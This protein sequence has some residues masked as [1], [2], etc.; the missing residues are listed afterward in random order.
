MA[1]EKEEIVLVP[2]P[3][4]SLWWVHAIAIN[5]QQGLRKLETNLH[6]KKLLALLGK[7]IPEL[8]VGLL[9][10][11]AVFQAR[12]MAKAYITTN[13]EWGRR[14]QIK[15]LFARHPHLCLLVGRHTLE[16]MPS[17]GVTIKKRV[18]Q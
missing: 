3:T 6:A 11:K 5:V 7:P 18:L 12:W 9:A 14:I 4:P 10:Q 13:T 17:R 2:R 15:P 8:A 1:K 16:K